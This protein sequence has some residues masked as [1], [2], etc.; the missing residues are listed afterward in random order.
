MPYRMSYPLHRWQT[1]RRGAVNVLANAH[2]DIGDV[3]GPGRPPEFGRPL[4][5]AYILRVVAEFQGFARDLHDLAA[6]RI[7]DMAGVPNVHRAALVAASTMGRR[8]DRGNA[9][10]RAL[11]DD[12]K[13][14]GIPALSAR[15]AAHDQRWDVDK[16]ALDDLVRLRNALAHGNR[17]DLDRLRSTGLRD[18][19]TWAQ[20][21][22]PSLNRIT[23]ALDR[24][25]WDHLHGRFTQDPW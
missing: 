5:H 22:L 21:R 11:K 18:T 10:L 3:P 23:R 13:R 4:A 2:Q 17:T 14:L 8:L 24:V 6:D 25:V 19:R 15:L 9:D 20:R 7:V 16:D 12:F 1:E